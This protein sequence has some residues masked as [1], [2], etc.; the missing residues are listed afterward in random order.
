MASIYTTFLTRI[1]INTP[2]Y[3]FELSL[4]YVGEARGNGSVLVLSNPT[5]ESHVGSL[6]LAMAPVV[7][8]E[9]NSV[10]TLLSFDNARE[11]LERNGWCVFVEKFEGF[12]LTVAQEFALT[13]DGCRAK[14]GDVQLE[15]NEDFISQATDLPVVGQKWFKNSK[16]E[17]VPWSLFF[18]SMRITSCDRGMPVTTLKPRWHDLLAIVKQF[19]TC[20]GRHGLVFL[21]HLWLLMSFIDLPLN[22]PYFLLRSLYKMAK[23]FK[24]QKS[25]SILFHHCLIKIITIHQ[26]KLNDD[27]QDAFLLRNGFASSEIGQVE[28]SV[29]TETLIEPTIPPPSLLPGDPISNVEPSTY[30]DTTQPDTLPDLYPKGGVKSVRKS[31][32]KKCKGNVDIN[33]KSKK[34]AH[35]VSRCA[36]NKPKPCAD[37]TA[38]VLSKDSDSEIERFLTEEYPYSYGLCSGKPYDYVTN[39][40]PCLKD[41][42]DFPGIKLSSEPTGQ[43]ENSPTVNTITT[44]TQSIQPQCNECQSWT[45][46]YYRD[47]SLLQSRI[48]SLEDQVNLLTKEN[49]R[50]QTVAQTKDKLQKTTGSVVFKNVEAAT[51]IVN[52]KIV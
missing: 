20:E 34:S 25:D 40:P 37:Q 28:K 10:Q 26:L 36:R 35:W 7:R 4:H 33:Y 38:I 14:I 19:V 48:K 5:I 6:Q 31:A 47:V 39:L 44:N 27:C 18:T 22:M 32:K 42:P 21:Y 15:L 2:D 51:A 23:H 50:L 1:E 13:F 3:H 52:S 46:R 8:I 30:P 45:D 17:E 11:D 9:P 16:V 41:N 49:G 24:R 12:N 29:V 43:M